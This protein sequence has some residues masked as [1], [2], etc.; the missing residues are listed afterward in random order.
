[1]DAA[2][3]SLRV[4]ENR[5]S[6][7]VWLSGELD[8]A[9]A[10]MLDKCLQ[11]MNGQDITVDFSG[12]TFMDSSGLNVLIEK[13]AT[14]ADGTLVLRGVQPAQMKIFEVTGLDRLFSFEGSK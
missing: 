8:M 2:A 13:R 9:T 5:H 6:P 11:R 7:V 1:M 10:P 3:F 12:V 4:E 14:T